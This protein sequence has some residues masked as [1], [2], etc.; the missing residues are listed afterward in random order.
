GVSITTAMATNYGSR[1]SEKRDHNQLW[2]HKGNKFVIGTIHGE[3]IEIVAQYNPKELSRQVSAQWN[4][5]P[6]TSAKKAKTTE[7]KVWAE[8][9]K[10]TPR[11]VSLE[12]LFDGYEEG[13]S[14]APIVDS[15]EALTMPI[16]MNSNDASERRPQLCVAVWGT[17]QLRCV[18]ESVATKLTMFDI[19]GEPLRASCTIQL[20][21]VDVAAMLQADA[22]DSATSY[23]KDSGGYRSARN[24]HKVIPYPP[25]DSKPT[26]VPPYRQPDDEPTQ[27]Q[28]AKTETRPQS[29]RATTTAPASTDAAA[30]PAAAETQ[31]APIVTD[32]TVTDSGSQP[33]AVSSTDAAPATPDAVGTPS[34]KVNPNALDGAQPGSG[35][36]FESEQGTPSAKVN[37]NALDGDQPGTGDVFD[38]DSAPAPDAVSSADAQDPDA[39]RMGVYKKLE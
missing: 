20:K 27:M 30:A 28:S 5:N 37:P 26:K 2:T 34:A 16:D 10:T 11:S 38:K 35:D 22:N 33:D 7:N 23:R 4:D 19:A 24:D 21:E 9:G 14:V 39:K 1:N 6:N 31:D 29:K 36:V 3:P 13:I 25:E 18:V 8:Y 17:Q 32:A 12:L 15:L